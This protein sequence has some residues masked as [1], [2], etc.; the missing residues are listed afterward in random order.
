MSTRIAERRAETQAEI[1]TAAWRLAARDGIAGL[2]LRDLAAEVG[3]QAPSLYTYFDGK[4]AIYDALFEQG[5]RELNERML[6]LFAGLPDGADRNCVLTSAVEAFL[7][8]CAEHPARY[9]LM[10]T[11]A[12]PGWEP[13]AEAY[14]VSL[15][16]YGAMVDRFAA[17]G[18]EDPAHVDLYTALVS[19]L[20]AQQLANDP[21]G[22]RWRDLAPQAAEMFLRH[23][24]EETR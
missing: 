24:D 14:A 6:Q 2:S 16:N 21:G 10:F 1:L 15:E 11:H 5:Y 18:I 8:F 3:M 19:G 23:I 9:Q 13:S 20:A 22:T 12:I 4:S 17:Y 7:D